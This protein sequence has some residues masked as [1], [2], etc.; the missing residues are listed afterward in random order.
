[1]GH[2]PGH[3]GA[4]GNLTSGRLSSST[5]VD[6]HISQLRLKCQP[7]RVDKSNTS[8]CSPGMPAVL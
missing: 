3:F 2:T 8:P 4:K 1:M 7:A 5:L 6:R